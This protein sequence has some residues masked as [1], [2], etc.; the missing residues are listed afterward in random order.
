VEEVG[1]M[2][3]LDIRRPSAGVRRGGYIAAVVVNAVLLWL[4]HAWPGWEAVPFLTEDTAQV[5]GLV[6]ASLVVGLVANLVY[7][8]ADPAW[9]T[10][11]GAVVTTA[12]GLAAA[13]RLLQVFPF[14][15]GDDGS[16]W[17]LLARI[18]LWV[19]IVGSII[20]IVVN[21]VALVRALGARG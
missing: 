21:L 4:V 16:G 15:F 2:T 20:G 6:T 11:A 7:L 14:D 18:L 5:L 12:V 13:V 3:D 10:A 8:L 19:G 9:L 17:E 1:V